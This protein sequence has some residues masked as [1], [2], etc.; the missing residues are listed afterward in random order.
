MA[1]GK[2]VDLTASQKRRISKLM[3]QTSNCTTF[4]ADDEIERIS[5]RVMQQQLADGGVL[6]PSER[7]TPKYIGTN[8]FTAAAAF[9][10]TF[11][12][13]IL[14]PPIGRRYLAWLRK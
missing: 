12:A 2:W 5:C 13:V 10:L 9:A 7:I 11:A 4:L 8:V 6:Y 3:E 14:G 1:P